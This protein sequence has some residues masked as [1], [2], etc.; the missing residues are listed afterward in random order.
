MGKLG[1]LVLVS[2]L[3]LTGCAAQASAAPE[4][5]ASVAPLTGVAPLVVA[6]AEQTARDKFLAGVKKSPN[7]WRDGV[8][9]S[10][11]ALLEEATHACKLFAQG[12][13][14]EEIAALAGTT[15]I[16]QT[17]GAAVAVWASRNFCTEYNTDNR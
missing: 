8:I 14:Y 6:P 5:K 15:D 16:Q 17:N 10:D 2:V 3:A 12:K 11:D 9:P 1:G 7:A 4:P 13:S